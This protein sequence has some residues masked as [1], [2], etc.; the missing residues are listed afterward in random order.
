MTITREQIADLQPGDIVQFR[1]VAWPENT[2]L[3]GPLEGEEASNLYVG[4]HCVRYGKHQPRLPLLTGAA[5]LII[6]ARK[7]RQVYVNHPRTGPVPGDVVRDADD[8]DTLTWNCV[9]PDHTNEFCWRDT[10]RGGQWRPEDL[11]T[12]LRLLVDGETGQVVQ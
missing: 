9:E 6:L 1:Y 11:P 10:G 8:D 2:F 5:T 7:P 4:G 3:Q 12:R